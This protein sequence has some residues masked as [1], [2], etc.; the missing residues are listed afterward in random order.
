MK[1]DT[2]V[3]VFDEMGKSMWRSI[4]TPCHQRW[5]GD[6]AGIPAQDLDGTLESSSLAAAAVAAVGLRAHSVFPASPPQ[7]QQ[8]QQLTACE[9][10]LAHRSTVGQEHSYAKPV[11]GI[12]SWGMQNLQPVWGRHVHLVTATFDIAQQC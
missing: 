8:C 3:A 7:Q 2:L 6:Q 5:Q 9:P 10:C 1:S 11:L 4:H 12:R